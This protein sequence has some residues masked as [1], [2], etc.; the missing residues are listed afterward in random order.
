MTD[1]QTIIRL[2]SMQG[3]VAKQRVEI[4]RLTDVVGKLT[5]E[6]DNLLSDIRW[7]RGEKQN[8]K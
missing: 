8:G 5:D 6:R 1:E 7:M 3:K 2:Q 4:S